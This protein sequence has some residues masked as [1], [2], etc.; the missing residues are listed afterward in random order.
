MVNARRDSVPVSVGAV[1][2]SLRIQGIAFHGPLRTPSQRVIF[3][4]DGYIL[5][6]SELLHLLEQN[7]LNRDGI[8]EL[9]KCTRP[10]ENQHSGD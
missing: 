8:Q 3:L 2:D 9:A 10:Q 4:V 6:Q 1:I 5:L 7:K